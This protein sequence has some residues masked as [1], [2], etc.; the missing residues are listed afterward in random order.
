MQNESTVHNKIALRSRYLQ[1]SN[2]GRTKMETKR[3]DASTV[4]NRHGERESSAEDFVP[5]PEH[6]PER[7]D[8]HRGPSL[9]VKEVCGAQG[10]AGHDL[11]RLRSHV[12]WGY[13]GQVESHQDYGL[14]THWIRKSSE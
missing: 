13:G 4:T 1:T 3:V 7:C 11:A 12:L 5:P 14:G 2:H 9:G 6:S 10:S 8:V